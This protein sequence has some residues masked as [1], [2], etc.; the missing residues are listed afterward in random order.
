MDKVIDGTS[1]DLV[2]IGGGINGTGIARDAAGRG[3]KVCLCDQGDLAQGSSSASAKLIH[4]GLRYLEFYKLSLAH[5]AL[6]EREVLLRTAGHIVWPMEFVLPHS[7][8]FRPSWWLRAGLFLY[9]HLAWRKRLPNSYSVDL[10][11]SRFGKPCKSF[12]KSGFVYSDTWVEDARLIILNAVDAAARGA[13]ILPR[14][15]FVRA[16]RDGSGWHVILC[17]EKGVQSRITARQ[18]VNAGGGGVAQVAA[19]IQDGAE[20]PKPVRWVKGSHIIVPKLY[21]GEHGYVLQHPDRRM[22]F[23]LPFE[24]QFTLIGTTDQTAAEVQLGQHKITPHDINYL[25]EA[26]NLY[27]KTQ[28]GHGDVRFSYAGVRPLFEAPGDR[29]DVQDLRDYHLVLE[30]NCLSVFG[31]KTT[32]FRRLAETAVNTLLAARNTE[33]AAW[34]AHTPLPGGDIGA[35]LENF[36]TIV[37]T[38]YPFLPETLAD[39]LARSYGTRLHDILYGAKALADLGTDFG[40]G[41][42]AR[43]VDY[44]QAHEWAVTPDDILLRRTKLGLSLDPA[45]KDRLAEYMAGKK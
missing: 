6:L 43:E 36:I 7:A 17:D 35:S 42:H 38:R 31:G 13:T 34:T 39:R 20:A 9:D 11:S 45:A 15:Q 32:S 16:A 29:T 27:F 14:M 33:A 24:D 18:L 19:R 41:L 26:V 10:T 12:V 44:L 40:G 8:T 22:V 23:V 37:K 25:L 2:I 5:A 4:G 1:Y 3:L 30:N 21:E 28:V